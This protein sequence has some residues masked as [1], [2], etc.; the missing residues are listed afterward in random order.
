MPLCCLLS[1]L[2]IYS[3]VKWM[4]PRSP[5]AAGGG[6]QPGK[7][8]LRGKLTNK[9]QAAGQAGP[10]VVQNKGK[11]PAG[12]LDGLLLR[13]GRQ[14]KLPVEHDHDEEEEE[15]GDDR[16]CCAGVLLET[17]AAVDSVWDVL[18]LGSA[19]CRMFHSQSG[20][21]SLKAAHLPP[22][23]AHSRGSGWFPSP[24]GQG[25]PPSRSLR[26]RRP[27]KARGPQNA[28]QSAASATAAPGP[29]SLASP[30]QKKQ[31]MDS[32]LTPAPVAQ[33]ALPTG[34]GGLILSDRSQSGYKS[35]YVKKGAVRPYTARCSFPPCSNNTLAGGPFEDPAKAALVFL[36][37][38]QQVHP[39][40]AAG[41][42]RRGTTPQPAA[43]P[44]ASSLLASSSRPYR[45][46]KKE[47]I[48][49]EASR[50]PIY[51]EL[52]VLCLRDQGGYEIDFKVHS[53]TMLVK[54]M[55]AY[56]KEQGID[57]RTLKTL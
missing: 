46:P 35:V 47:A 33:P 37:H 30:Q 42:A 56:C 4:S 45:S 52:L 9:R 44:A 36:Q 14:G 53:S 25:A 5:L 43:A 21:G 27:Q 29:S 31:R 24:G 41:P 16:A 17:Q 51:A 55:K 34:G 28:E 54:V 57:V 22:P 50:D 6:K 32:T 39:E 48:V 10:P 7:L 23:E 19:V 13:R 1:Q 26:S 8:D 3:R 12:D 2:I 11:L 20:G 18:V 38:C 49:V 15:L 40:E